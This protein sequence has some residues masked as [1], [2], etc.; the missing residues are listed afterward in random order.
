ME[1]KTPYRTLIKRINTKKPTTEPAKH[2]RRALKKV[3]RFSF[4]NLMLVITLIFLFLP[5]LVIIFYSFNANKGS[6]FP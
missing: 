6:A 1:L 2:A 5:L 3:N 4:S